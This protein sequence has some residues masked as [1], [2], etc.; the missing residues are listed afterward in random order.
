MDP[1]NDFSEQVLVDT[2]RLLAVCEKLFDEPRDGLFA[3]IMSV[4]VLAH[5]V[6]MPLDRL[7]EGV[8]AAYRDLRVVDDKGAMQ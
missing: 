4:A 2:H 8:S 3:G 7:L 5:A 6:Q 1:L